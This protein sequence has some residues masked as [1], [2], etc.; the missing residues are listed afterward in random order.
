M[1]RRTTRLLICLV[2]L[3]ALCAIGAEKAKRV[4]VT[5]KAMQFIPASI[6]VHAG[7]T[8]VWINNDDRD[9]SVIATDG[10]FKS[11]N[12]SSGEKY[13]HQFTAAGTIAYKCG[14]HPRMKGTVVVQSN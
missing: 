4:D 7:D 5:I 12:I 13:E 8:V 9:H 6:T 14:Y 1:V 10:S 3:F 11:G 2:A